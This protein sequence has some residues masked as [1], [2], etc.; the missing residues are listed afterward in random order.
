MDVFLFPCFHERLIILMLWWIKNPQI[1]VVSLAS[2]PGPA[3]SDLYNIRGPNQM[4]KNR[5]FG[6]PICKELVLRATPLVG[7]SQAG[8]DALVESICEEL[9]LRATTLVGASHAEIRRYL[10]PDR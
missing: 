8:D 3:D 2:P 6:C 9:V 10:A 7:P 4:D 1:W 5:P